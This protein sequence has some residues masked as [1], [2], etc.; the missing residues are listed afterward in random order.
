MGPPK[1]FKGIEL[2]FQKC[3]STGTGQLT[4]IDYKVRL[5][6]ALMPILLETNSSSLSI[7]TLKLDRK[8]DTV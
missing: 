2:Y 6:T 5:F 4:Q 8:R 3:A 7:N 1:H